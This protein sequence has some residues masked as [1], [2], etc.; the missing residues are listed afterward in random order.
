MFYKHFT[1]IPVSVK[2]SHHAKDAGYATYHSCFVWATN[3][4]RAAGEMG[5]S[6][7]PLETCSE[8]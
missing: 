8:I 2:Y 4:V 5:H 7:K 6:Q 3:E 1:S